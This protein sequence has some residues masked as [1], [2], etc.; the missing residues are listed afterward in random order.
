MHTRPS[1][2]SPSHCLCHPFPHFP[3]PFPSH[4][5]L[6]IC[7]SASRKCTYFFRSKISFSL[8]YNTTT[9]PQYT[10]P[11]CPLKTSPLNLHPPPTFHPPTGLHHSLIA[12]SFVLKTFSSTP[13]F[14][15]SV[16]RLPQIQR[17]SPW[18]CSYL[19]P[20]PFT[21]VSKILFPWYLQYIQVPLYMIV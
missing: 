12:H 10:H 17:H 8:L 3:L 7:I 1:F 21:S 11:K 16:H 13:S 4:S 18:S 14:S 19:F 15:Y 20:F 2:P 5:L 9:S 6:P